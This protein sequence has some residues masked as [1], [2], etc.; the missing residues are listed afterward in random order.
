[1]FH[2]FIYG[3]ILVN[4]LS[5][6]HFHLMTCS[7]NSLLFYLANHHESGVFPFKYAL[8]FPTGLYLQHLDYGFRPVYQDGFIIFS[9]IQCFA[10]NFQSKLCIIQFFITMGKITKKHDL[11]GG[12]S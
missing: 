4:P 3:K 5:P 7:D 10:C 6:L 9:Y 11:T 2:I 8:P 1:M 12:K